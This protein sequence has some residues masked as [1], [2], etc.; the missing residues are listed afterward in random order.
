MKQLDLVAIGRQPLQA[1]PKILTKT[2]RAY[3]RENLRDFSRRQALRER[4]RKEYRERETPRKPRTK[5]EHSFVKT[6]PIT[7]R[8]IF[9]EPTGP[10]NPLGC[11]IRGQ[12]P[13]E[14]FRKGEFWYARELST[15]KRN[16]FERLG[17]FNGSDSARQGV[18][19][20]FV[21]RLQAWQVWG[22][23]PTDEPKAREFRPVDR[24][25]LPDEFCDLG[26]GK[27]GWYQAEDLTHILH[28]PTIPPKAR[29]PPAACGAQVPAKCFINNRANVQPT[30]KECAQV[31]KEN[32][33]TK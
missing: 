4:T 32:Y 33:K 13:V 29:V 26:D 9:E 25:L 15:P 12:Q 2:I 28:A 22:T 3:V 21:R 5:Q 19:N 7:F 10:L 16:V 8:A 31:W 11:K 23:P 17:K 14:V 24:V 1:E 27:A 6:I 20:S 30:C 18:E